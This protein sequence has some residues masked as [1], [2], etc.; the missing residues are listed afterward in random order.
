LRRWTSQGGVLNGSMTGP[1][2]ME[3]AATDPW[4]N[5]LLSADATL[6]DAIRNLDQTALRIVLAVSLD[7]ALSGT[8]TDGDIRRG[9]LRGL[10]LS[11]S[12]GL[13]INRDPL[14]VP[15]QVSRDTVLQIMQANKIHQIP[16]VDANRHVVG[17]HRWEE[18]IVPTQ[19]TNLMVIMAGGQG[20][21]LRPHTDN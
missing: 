15:P 13:I 5:A 18:L 3:I 17:L 21:R 12:I 7:G 4:R 2:N 9:L 11:D 1:N 14:V 6:Q 20:S 19:R 16:V 10:G 8:L